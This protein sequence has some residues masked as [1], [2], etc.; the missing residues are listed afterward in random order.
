MNS[1]PQ[2]NGAEGPSDGI[3]TTDYSTKYD[4]NAGQLTALK[5]K[6]KKDKDFVQPSNECE[7]EYALDML[8]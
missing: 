8:I 2:T 7:K 1:E 3:P 4:L 5:N 6:F